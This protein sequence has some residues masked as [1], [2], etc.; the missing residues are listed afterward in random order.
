MSWGP[1]E[2]P[3]HHNQHEIFGSA[4]GG[5][6]GCDGASGTTVHLSN[7]YV[8]PI[9]IVES[10]FPT[11]VVRFELIPGSGGDGQWRGGLSF[12]REYVVDQPATILYRGDKARFPARGIAGGQD[13]RRS[14][15]LLDPGGT[16]ETEMPVN[17]RIELQ[18]GQ[19]F[20][21][22]AAG[23]GGYGDPAHRDPQARAR[24]VEDGYVVSEP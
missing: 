1:G 11:R 23:G 4:Y 13:G 10:E 6:H 17:C 15:F 20:R 18:P 19:S 24:D 9:E 14:R 5:G 22:E 8:T 21:V 3:T 12:A 16:G 2:R 7:I